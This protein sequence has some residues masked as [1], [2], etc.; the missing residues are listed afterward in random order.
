MEI[1]AV[2]TWRA[3]ST[4][5]DHARKS[6]LARTFGSPRA[7]G[8]R[9][10]VR[11]AEKAAESLRPLPNETLGRNLCSKSGPRTGVGVHLDIATIR[12]G[13]LTLRR[14]PTMP[15]AVGKA[16]CMGWF[17]IAVAPSRAAQTGGP[18]PLRRPRSRFGLGQKVQTMG[19]ACANRP[20]IRWR[21]HWISMGWRCPIAQALAALTAKSEG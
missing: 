14:R 15:D 18:F 10:P 9:Q 12:C 5:P 17:P 3:P 13:Q 11:N 16:P 19:A 21:H 8:K 6:A 1:R 20:P 2:E 7:R 4:R